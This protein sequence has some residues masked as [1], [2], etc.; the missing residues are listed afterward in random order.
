MQMVH[1]AGSLERAVEW[2]L[3]GIPNAECWQRERMRLLHQEMERGS[4]AMAWDAV[5]YPARW[6]ELPDPPLVVFGRGAPYQAEESVCHVAIVGTRK[7]TAEARRVSF[8]LGKAIAQ[9]GATVVSGLARG[10]DAAAHRGAC[11]V[12]CRTVG[13]LGGGVASIQPR[14]SRP[15]AERM[16]ELGGAIFSERPTGAPVQRW[17]FAARNRLVVGLCDAVVMVQSPAKGGALISAQL[18]LDLGVAC[19]VYRPESGL[20]TA[21]WAG[22]RRLLTEFPA[23]GWQAVEELADAITGDQ[24]IERHCVAERD[25][26]VAFRPT[27]RHLMESRGAQ[28]D[29]LALRTGMDDAEMRRQLHAMEMGGWVRRMPGGWFVPLKI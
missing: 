21:P 1:R 5:D 22:N 4:W 20:N 7:C 15:I 18:A 14:S 13:V 26:P 28:L 8:E 9:R 17:H 27:W 16:V 24:R 19:W 23:M 3:S 10:V 25:V 11:Y 12:G 2:A 29:A 6:R